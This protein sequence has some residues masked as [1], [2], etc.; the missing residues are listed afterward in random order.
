MRVV[1]SDPTGHADL[2]AAQASRAPGVHTPAAP[3]GAQPWPAAFHLVEQLPGGLRLVGRRT[4]NGHGLVN[5]FYCIINE[6]SGHGIAVD[7]AWDLGAVRE[8]FASRGATL[9]AVLLTHAHADHSGLAR[10]LAEQLGCEVWMSEIE[11]RTYDFR[12]PNLR[13]LELDRRQYI[14][15]IPLEAWSTPGHTAGSVCF[16]VGNAVMTGD[17]LFAEG[18][19]ACTGAGADPAELFSSLERLKARLRHEDRVLPGH[20]YRFPPGRAFARVMDENVY[21][22]FRRVDEFVRFRMRPQPKVGRQL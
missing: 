17:T 13:L 11:Q 6:A 3:H 19:G 10:P 22:Q 9:D 12:A 5:Y 1:I 7:P 15:S 21:L 4:S 2:G 18:C 16:R 14:G 20:S 8:V